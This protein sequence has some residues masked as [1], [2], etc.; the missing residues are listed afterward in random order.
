MNTFEC[1]EEEIQIFAESLAEM[2]ESGGTKVQ[3]EE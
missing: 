2:D 1:T 3:W